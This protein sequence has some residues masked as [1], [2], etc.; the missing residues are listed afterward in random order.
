MTISIF[1]SSS[2]NSQSAI[3]DTPGEVTFTVKTVTAN[4]NFAP[5][6][7][8]AIWVEDMQGFVKTKLLR[9][10]QRKQYLYTWRSV[11]ND[12]V[13]DATTGATLTSHQTHTIV[14]DCTDIDGNV[15]P[16]GDYTIR[17]EF[18][19]KHAQGPLM[20][21]TFTKGTEEQHLTPADEDNFIDMSLDYIPETT[22]L[23]S[24]AK[25]N[26]QVHPNPGSGIF[27]I[28]LPSVEPYKMDVYDVTGNHIY[29]QRGIATGN[30]IP[31]D[32]S[33]FNSGIYFVQIKQDRSIQVA[34]IVKQ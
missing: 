3:S 6:H 23:N 34:R 24:S 13:V 7:V 12:N 26:I 2:T 28:N 16:D 27:K 22:G 10:N 32:L 33:R 4:G 30:D 11:S 17:V 1:N 9:A 19:E 5:K 18:T 31:F 25:N 14:W 29:H 20:D 8:M 21:V 15:V